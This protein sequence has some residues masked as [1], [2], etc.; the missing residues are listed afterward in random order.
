MTAP[1]DLVFL[2]HLVMGSGRL[3]AAEVAAAK[4]Q[5][6]VCESSDWFWWFGNYNPAQTVASFD[7]LYRRNL[8][9]LYRLLKLT[10]P[11]QVDVPLSRGSSAQSGTMVRSGLP[12]ER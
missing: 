3:T 5:L 11:A 6:A 2:W 7:Q 4:S 1:L 10:P 9:N 8:A 12:P